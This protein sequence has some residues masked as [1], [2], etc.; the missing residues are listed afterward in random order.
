MKECD[1]SMINSII[2]NFFE[3]GTYTDA[4]ELIDALLAS[5]R[6]NICSLISETKQKDIIT[7]SIPQ[8]SSFEHGT[9]HMIK[10]LRMAGD[11]GPSFLEIGQH[12]IESGSDK[13]AYVKY[14][15][16]HAKLA[17]V[18]G[19][20][21]IRKENVR[22]AYLSELGKA[23]EK[24]SI[25]EQK[26]CFVKLAGS[27]P[28]VQYVIKQGIANSA[29]LEKAMRLY[30]SESTAKRRRKNTWDMVQKLRER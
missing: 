7:Y 13:R 19:V 24:R 6:E 2:Y 30:L 9:T 5:S 28:M 16:N 12:Y 1:E 25:E 20:V 27:V 11:Y 23:L 22:R 3:D 10:Y 14:G 18:L 8:Y 4:D 15:E 17:E 29:I 21:E 26:E